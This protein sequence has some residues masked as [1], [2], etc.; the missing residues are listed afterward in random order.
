[1]APPVPV[2]AVAGT[3]EPVA[4]PSVDSSSV[5]RQLE[6]AYYNGPVEWDVVAP[7][8]LT[9]GAVAR[10]FRKDDGIV[11]AERYWGVHQFGGNACCTPSN[12]V[13]FGVLVSFASLFLAPV[14]FAR[15]TG[16]GI[17]SIPVF[18]CALFPICV[19]FAVGVGGRLLPLRVAIF[20]GVLRADHPR[21]LWR[22]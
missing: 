15:P 11:G 10:N 18:S 14:S 21:R 5:H 4:P 22:P 12:T 6:V 19:P 16:V 3:V 13:V 9:V 8:G 1:M 17:A 2:A 7:R 20:R